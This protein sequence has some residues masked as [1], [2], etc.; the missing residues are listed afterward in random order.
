MAIDY[1]KLPVD[2]RRTHWVGP[3][4][5][6][7]LGIT[8]VEEPL[9]AELNNT[10]G[11]SGMLNA[12]AAIS[13]NDYDF[14]ISESDT[15]NEPSLADSSSYEEFGT[16][17]YG[18][19]ISYYYPEDYDDNSNLISLVY[20]LTDKPGELNDMAVRI[21]GDLQ[22]TVAA[23]DGQFVSA[24]RVQGTAEANPFTPGESKRRSVTYISKGDFSHFVVVGDHEITPIAP[25]SF[26]VGSKGRI[27]ASQQGRDVSCA[28][29][30]KF[31]SSNGAVVNI[32]PGGWFEVTGA[33]GSSATITIED[34]GTGDTA[35]VPVTVTA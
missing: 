19:G 26:T 21:D 31:S 8:N 35:T 24:Y 25:S 6:T 34:E 14:G 28:D 32:Y 3:S 1:T 7:T 18:G 16:A 20:D 30:I 23:A 2:K 9:A 4:G 13:W 33:S 17:N 27:R 12:S 29:Y 22:T 5:G 15:N 11:T 10:G